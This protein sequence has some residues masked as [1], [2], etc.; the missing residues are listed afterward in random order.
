MAYY[1]YVLRTPMTDTVAVETP[2]GDVAVRVYV[3]G[4]SVKLSTTI[5][6]AVFVLFKSA[7]YGAGALKVA[8]VDAPE[9]E[10]DNETLTIASE[11]AGTTKVPVA[12]PA[13]G[14]LL[15]TWLIAVSVTNCVVVAIIYLLKF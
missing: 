4:P 5:A 10:T 12:V 13:G 15:V 1:E 9:V 14:G 2:P 6:E 11:F 7:L 3:P 8:V